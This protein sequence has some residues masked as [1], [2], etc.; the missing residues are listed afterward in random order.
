MCFTDIASLVGNHYHQQQLA[1]FEICW[2]AVSNGKFG[3]KSDSK[4]SR[5]FSCLYTI[6]LA[7]RLGHGLERLATI[8]YFVKHGWY[9]VCQLNL[10]MQSCQ[11]LLSCETWMIPCLSA[12]SVLSVSVYDSWNIDG[13]L[14]VNLIGLCSPFSI[15]I[16]YLVKHRLFHFVNLFSPFNTCIWYLVKHRWFP[17]S[18]LILA[19]Q[20]VQYLGSDLNSKLLASSSVGIKKSWY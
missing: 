12:Y 4:L 14:S 17:V 8:W 19:M 3:A 6:D 13:S 2:V 20:A 7:P 5:L 1:N 16:C 15:C 18:E 11:C 10:T 9:P